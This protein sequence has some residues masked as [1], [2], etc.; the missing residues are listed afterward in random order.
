MDGSAFVGGKPRVFYEIGTQ[1][2]DKRRFLFFTAFH[3][4][5]FLGRAS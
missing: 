2:D 5:V 1:G 4:G 3:D